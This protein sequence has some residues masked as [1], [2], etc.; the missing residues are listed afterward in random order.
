MKGRDSGTDTTKWTTRTAKPT[1]TASAATAAAARGKGTASESSLLMERRECRLH[2]LL[3]AHC[4]L[5]AFTRLDSWRRSAAERAVQASRCSRAHPPVSSCA[6]LH[7]TRSSRSAISTASRSKQTN[8]THT[9][10]I[11]HTPLSR[12]PLIR[13]RWRTILSRAARRAWSSR[14]DTAQRQQQQA[15]RRLAARR[16]VTW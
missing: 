3:C 8:R 7:C 1:A 2:S 6:A 16:S 15:A 14:R 4:C 9:R 11:E 13:S 12:C 10:R 5:I